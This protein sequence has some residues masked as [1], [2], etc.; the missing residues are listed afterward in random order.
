MRCDDGFS[1]SS[2]V[3]CVLTCDFVRHDLEWP[4]P[5]TAGDILRRA[6][7]VLPRER[8]SPPAH[9]LRTRSEPAEP[10]DLMTVDYKGQ[11]LLGD[12]RY[13][14]PLTVVDQ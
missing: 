8:R 13:C 14:Y 6:N 5:S 11:F 2:S 12:H 4:A 1:D 3:G 9:P 10:N 7:L